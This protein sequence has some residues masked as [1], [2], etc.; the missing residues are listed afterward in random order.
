MTD[1]ALATLAVHAGEAADPATGALTPPLHMSAAFELPGF[2]PRLFDALL[3][4]STEPPFAYVRWGNPTHSVLEA[5]MAALEGG[6]AALALASGMAADPEWQQLILDAPQVAAFLS[7]LFYINVHTAS[8]PGGEVRGQVQPEL[9][10]V[11][12][13]GMH[14]LLG[15]AMLALGFVQRRRRVRV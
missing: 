9:A 1:P 5:K 7:G 8:F 10:A 6:E 11:P 12:E 2:G 3:M 4:E 13:P 14:L 15:S